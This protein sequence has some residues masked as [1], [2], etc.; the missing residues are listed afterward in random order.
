[1]KKL[2]QSTLLGKTGP[3]NQLS[4]VR[5]VGD[6]KDEIAYFGS[7]FRRQGGEHVVIFDLLCL[8]ARV[9]NCAST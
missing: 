7:E 9:L 4:V 6:V 3:L 2:S 5:I 1:M 8:N